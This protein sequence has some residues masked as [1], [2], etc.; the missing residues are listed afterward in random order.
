MKIIE[1]L[2]IALLLPD[3]GFQKDLGL[4]VSVPNLR[5]ALQI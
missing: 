2:L 3:E 4:E 5:A 1:G